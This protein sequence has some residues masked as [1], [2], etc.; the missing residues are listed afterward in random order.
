MTATPAQR[1]GPGRPAGGGD[2][3]AALLEAARAQFAEKGYG[4]ASVRGIAREAGVDP[5][6]VHHYFGSKEQVFVAAMELPFQPA[7]LLPQVLA[8]DPSG[9]GERL[10]RLFLGVWENPD[11]RTPMLGMV[12]SAFTSEQGAT[13][14]REFVGSALLSRVVAATGPLDPLRVQAAAAH[15]VGI[16]MLRHVVRLEPLAS[17]PQDDIVALVGPTLQRYLTP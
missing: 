17:A 1:R 10:A 12:R 7:E 15:M 11:F 5:A 3:R 6:L 9:L 16:V 13:M 4:G 14:L 8:G 2:R